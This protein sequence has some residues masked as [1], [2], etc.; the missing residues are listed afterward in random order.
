MSLLRWMLTLC[1]ALVVRPATPPPFDVVQVGPAANHKSFAL[2]VNDRNE[3]VG[4]YHPGDADDDSNQVFLWNGS[5]SE[6][7]RFGARAF[8]TGINLQGDIVGQGFTNSQWRAW[9]FRGGHYEL[10]PGYGAEAINDR[11]DIVGRIGSDAY[12]ISVDPPRH[13]VGPN[14]DTNSSCWGNVV[15]V[16]N[17]GMALLAYCSASAILSNYHGTPTAIHLI[18]KWHRPV[19]STSFPEALNESGQVVGSFKM[20]YYPAQAGLWS[21]GDWHELGTLLQQPSA[22]LDIN[23]AGLMVGH[24]YGSGS[25]VL[26]L[27]NRV[28]YDLTTLAN[29]PE[30]FEVITA[31][32]INNQNSIA[33]TMRR[34]Q[35]FRAILLRTN[36]TSL[37]LPTYEISEPST[38]LVSGTNVTVS[39]RLVDPQNHPGREITKVVYTLFW[40]TISG[41]DTIYYTSYTDRTNVVTSAPFSVNFPNLQPRHYV[42]TAEV[43]DNTGL[44]A[45]TLPKR[46]VFTGETDVQARLAPHRSPLPD[47]F[48]FRLSGSPAYRYRLEVSHNLRDWL[49]LSEEEEIGYFV[50]AF[51][52][53]PFTFYRAVTVNSEY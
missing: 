36:G 17:S 31:R 50:D 13:L 38:A 25:A 18:P 30:G 53:E 11:G 22:A 40:R 19:V 35:D 20:H 49:P 43:H 15:D 51:R 41:S 12:L 28:G 6:L 52:M 21:E 23:E 48:E 4:V 2:D 47:T 29:L 32:A 16:N 1:T 8:P 27:T 44:R 7:P 24:V 5:F 34:G 9:L 14:G 26:W 10:F 42:V 33:G 39:V 37:N 3:V 45:I 46:F